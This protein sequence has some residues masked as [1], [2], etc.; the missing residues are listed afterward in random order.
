MRGVFELP[1]VVCYHHSMPQSRPEIKTL[2]WDVDGVLVNTE[3]LHFQGWR[4]LL[5][6]LGHNLT[7]E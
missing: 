5:Q 4:K 1:N 2:I 3:L 6:E 7:L